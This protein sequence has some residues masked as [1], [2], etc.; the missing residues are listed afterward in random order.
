M[1]VYIRY[2]RRAR[3]LL[4]SI[5][6]CKRKHNVFLRFL[7]GRAHSSSLFLTLLF[8]LF[9]PYPMF[10]RMEC[11]LH[12]IALPNAPHAPPPTST[13]AY[14]SLPL[15][16]ISVRLVLAMAMREHVLF[17]YTNN[18]FK[19]GTTH[20]HACA[21]CCVVLFDKPH[22]RHLAVQCLASGAPRSVGARRTHWMTGSLR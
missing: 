10:E 4:G 12:F 17:A 15:S 14:D 11:K 6:A 22:P 13:W 16:V 8:L 2:N 9:P 20:R 21:P 3:V 1:I 18:L 19:R 5:P 7:R